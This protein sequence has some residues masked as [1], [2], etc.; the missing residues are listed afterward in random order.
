MTLCYFMRS[1]ASKVT[2]I[3][4][5]QVFGRVFRLLES[6]PD[7][8]IYHV[9]VYFTCQ[10]VL[11][12]KKIIGC[13]DQS[14]AIKTAHGSSLHNNNIGTDNKTKHCQCKLYKKY[15]HLHNK[16]YSMDLFNVF[17]KLFGIIFPGNYNSLCFEFTHFWW[18]S[19]AMKLN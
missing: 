8:G 12:A 18:K 5:P 19:L 2:L 14:W 17:G 15:F 1:L 4:L 3:F 7:C 9:E 10:I 11:T 13:G 6:K 16:T